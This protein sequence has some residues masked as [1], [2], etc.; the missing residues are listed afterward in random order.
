MCREIT[1]YKKVIQQEFEDVGP[2]NYHDK[3]IYD[4]HSTTS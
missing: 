1:L 2:E 3:I 4:F